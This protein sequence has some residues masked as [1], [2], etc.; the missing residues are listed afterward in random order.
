MSLS[1]LCFKLGL[2]FGFPGEAGIPQ[3]DPGAFFGMS[4]SQPAVTAET[5]AVAGTTPLFAL[6][7]WARGRPDCLHP[8]AS[9]NHHHIPPKLLL[10]A[11][12]R[13]GNGGSERGSGC[14]RSYSWG[15]S[16][17]RLEIRCLRFWGS[18]LASAYDDEASGGTISRTGVMSWSSGSRDRPSH[19]RSVC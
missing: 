2:R 11:S 9:L 19:T 16:T 18:I 3:L 6:P 17:A 10:L 14:P 12:L 5:S 13:G 1:S 7:P 8:T 4:K 15:A